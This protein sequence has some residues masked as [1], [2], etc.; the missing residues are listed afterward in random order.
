MKLN[1][2]VARF[3]IAG[4]FAAFATAGLVAAP[5]TAAV[6]AV[7]AAATVGSSHANVPA[8]NNTCQYHHLTFT[9][10]T[11][12]CA[13]FINWTCR[14]HNE[15]PLNPA[16]DFVANTCFFYV[17]LYTNPNETGQTLCIRPDSR[18]SVRPRWHSFQVIVGAC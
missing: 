1:R 14:A 2:S 15:H 18:T 11:D 3:A 4:L 8:I 10:Y 5:A 6:A 17:L 12:G 9:T 13:H 7:P 16:P